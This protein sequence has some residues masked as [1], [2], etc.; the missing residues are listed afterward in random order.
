MDQMVL[1]TQQ[2]L[3][4]TYGDVSGFQKAPENGQTGWATIYSLREALQSELKLT[5]LGEG[6]GDQTKDALAKVI[7]TIKEDSSSK[8]V[9]L[10]KGAFWCKGISPNSFTESY[11]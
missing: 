8:I 2:W 9:K 6:F 10:I 3:N 11:D 5:E 4:K 1:G 7:N